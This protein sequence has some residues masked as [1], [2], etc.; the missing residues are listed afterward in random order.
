MA[1]VKISGLPQVTIISG[2]DVLPVVA[3][4][5]TSKITLKDFGNSIPGVT[6]S[7]SSSVAISASNAVTAQ[8]ASY[9]VNSISASYATT[10]SYSVTASYIEGEVY[11]ADDGHAYDELLS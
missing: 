2:S 4:T 1:N 9:V 6:S 3:T 10:A 11:W 5:T 8:T 7:I